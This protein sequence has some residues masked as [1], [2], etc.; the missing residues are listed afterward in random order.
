MS[1]HMIAYTSLCMIPPA[2][3]QQEVDAIVTVSRIRNAEQGVTGALVFTEERF[4][5]TL[6]GPATSVRAI[7]ESILGDSRHTNIVMIHDGPIA[8]RRFSRWSLAYR[9]YLSSL[10]ALIRAAEYEAQLASG[11]GLEELLDEME[12]LCM[13][14]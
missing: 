11:R 5:Q 6:E 12:R 4:A 13:D 3:Q 9:R 14:I 7:M 8:R 2:Y 1:V 10:D